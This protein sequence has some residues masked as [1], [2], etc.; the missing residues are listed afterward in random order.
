MILSSHRAT[1]L[2]LL[3]STELILSSHR[4][5]ELLLGSAELLLRGSELIATETSVVSRHSSLHFLEVELLV[6]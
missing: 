1:K 6:A 4:A 2:L 3:R 5:T